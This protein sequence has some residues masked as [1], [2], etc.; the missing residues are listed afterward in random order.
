MFGPS[1][2]GKSTL[3]NMIQQLIDPLYGHI[4]NAALLKGHSFKDT[5]QLL[6]SVMGRRFVTPSSE[7]PAN[8]EWRSEVVKAYVGNDQLL[9][10]RKYENPVEFRP[11]GG[12]WVAG[13]HYLAHEDQ[14]DSMSNRLVYLTFCQPTGQRLTP[15]EVSSLLGTESDDVLLH[16]ARTH[17][18]MKAEY[19][20]TRSPTYWSTVAFA[21]PEGFEPD[22][23]VIRTETDP[24]AAFFEDCVTITADPED[25]I[26]NADLY[27]VF[28]HWCIRSE[29]MAAIQVMTRRQFTSR[30]LKNRKGTVPTR[31]GSS[32]DR[33]TA[34][35]LWTPNGESLLME[36]QT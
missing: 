14:D 34:G 29:G 20:E 6:A 8:A 33:A 5:S 28:R 21:Y 23:D 26:S 3:F 11:E 27:A 18:A 17:A 24:W 4:T 25:R 7:V 12:M 36:T 35:L 31:L 9:A 32:G 13:N 10:E 15:E 30:V 22:L 16:L 1:N 19:A 2:T